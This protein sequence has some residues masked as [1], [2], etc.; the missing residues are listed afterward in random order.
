MQSNLEAHHTDG[1]APYWLRACWRLSGLRIYLAKAGRC[2]HNP[3]SGKI[4]WKRK[5]HPLQYSC[6]R[7]WPDRGASWGLLSTG[8]AK[9]QS[10][11]GTNLSMPHWLSHTWI[12]VSFLSRRSTSIQLSA[13][14]MWVFR[15]C[16][17]VTV[18]IKHLF[19]MQ[20]PH[21]RPGRH[22]SQ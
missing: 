8:V 7:T 9:S 21:T 16:I 20:W 13:T 22:C 17:K 4:P 5:W 12:Q 18:P 3:E 14:G 11:W 2:R 1:G 10:S 19:M 6:L 15:V